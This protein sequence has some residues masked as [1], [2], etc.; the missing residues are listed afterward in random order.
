M[1]TE[2]LPPND[3]IWSDIDQMLSDLLSKQEEIYEISDNNALVG[4]ADSLQYAHFT[5]EIDMEQEDLEIL[6]M[7]L[8]QVG[9]VEATVKKYLG[10]NYIQD[11]LESLMEEEGDNDE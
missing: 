5:E 8:K 7:F 3:E 2:G 1:T 4:F 10:E 6:L 11:Y 9:T